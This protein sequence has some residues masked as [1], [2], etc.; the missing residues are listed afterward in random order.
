MEEF[1]KDK[2]AL[3]WLSGAW[4]DYVGGFLPLLPV[5]LVQTAVSSGSFFLM[6]RYHSLLAAVPYI[7]LVVTPVSTG[8]AMVYINMARG[9]KARLPDLFS[10]FPV[11][12]RAL[13]VSLWLGCLTL[14]GTLAL[15]LPG[16]IIHLTYCF[17]EYA[18]VDRRTGIKAS[19]ALSRIIT[20]G[21]KS[22]L[23]PIFL[24]TL[25]V[26]MFAPD[27]VA[28]TGPFKNPDVSL[29][30]KPW[31]LAGAALKTLVFLPWLSLA[32]ARA[33][34]FL[35]TGPKPAEEPQPADA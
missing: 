9:G 16:L 19:F 30:L 20:D 17:S 1:E 12:H 35:L 27:I 4:D 21:W 5:L 33:Y 6:D 23:F 10:A 15:V 18:V 7:L 11:Y 13:A 28:V 25:L 8:A 29:N 3:A 32:M 31:N 26:N 34:E 24:L 2:A 14:G 22:R